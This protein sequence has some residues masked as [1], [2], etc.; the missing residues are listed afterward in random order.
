MILRKYR[1]KNL[2]NW[3][4]NSC[5]INI[6]RYMKMTLV[7][8]QKNHINPRSSS[9]PT[10]SLIPAKPT[11]HTDIWQLITNRPYCIL[12]TADHLILLITIKRCWFQYLNH[13]ITFLSSLILPWFPLKT[14]FSNYSPITQ[15]KDIYSKSQYF[16]PLIIYHPHSKFHLT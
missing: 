12:V 6:C 7:P 15:P 11:I 2:K 10:S 13:I 9:R 16:V 8:K 1:Y 5:D 3:D 4:V 14:M